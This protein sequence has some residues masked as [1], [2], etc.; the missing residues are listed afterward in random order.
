MCYSWDSPVR[1]Q[2]RP[3]SIRV[4]LVIAF[5]SD[6]VA[7]CCIRAYGAIRLF[8]QSSPAPLESQGLEGFGEFFD[9]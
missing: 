7:H 3:N 6:R 8:F 4:C 2:R 5:I 9:R 1:L